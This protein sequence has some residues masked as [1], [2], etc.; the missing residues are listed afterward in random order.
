MKNAW[1]LVKL[2]NFSHLIKMQRRFLGFPA[3]V[4]FSST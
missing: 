2:P 3:K 1:F 4:A